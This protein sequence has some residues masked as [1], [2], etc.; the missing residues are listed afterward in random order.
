[1]NVA[2]SAIGG[3][4][5]CWRAGVVVNRKK[6]YRLY[7]EE[8]LTVRRRKGR[9]R[10]TGTRAPIRCRRAES[11]AGASTSCWIQLCDGRRFRVLIVVEDFTRGA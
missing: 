7:R 8:R 1:M 11:R 10:A 5:F 2:G 4:I 9:K 3:C 6:T